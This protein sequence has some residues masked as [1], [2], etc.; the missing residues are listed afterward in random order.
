MLGFAVGCAAPAAALRAVTVGM[1]VFSSAGRLSDRWLDNQSNDKKIIGFCRSRSYQGGD[2]FLGDDAMANH[3]AVKRS[4]PVVC[5]RAGVLRRFNSTLALRIAVS[6]SIAASLTQSWRPA[7]GVEH[8]REI[9]CSEGNDK[10]TE[11]FDSDQKPHAL[12]GQ[13]GPS[14]FF[15]CGFPEGVKMR[16]KDLSGFVGNP[17]SDSQAVSVYRG[18]SNS[19]SQ[20]KLLIFNERTSAVVILEVQDFTSRKYQC[21]KQ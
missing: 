10:L 16:L 4:R 20:G 13:K 8:K 6:L 17:E 7:F 9:L 15:Y 3:G 12:W 1:S 11:Y 14:G 18:L 21:A 2:L 5:A 19:C